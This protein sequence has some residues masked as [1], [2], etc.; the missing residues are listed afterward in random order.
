M[1]TIVFKKELT[2]LPYHGRVIM[3]GKAVINE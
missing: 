2:T 3:F 1:N